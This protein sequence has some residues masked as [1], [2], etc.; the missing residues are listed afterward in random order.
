MKNSTTLTILSPSHLITNQIQGVPECQGL[1]EAP[2]FCGFGHDP[3]TLETR[4]ITAKSTAIGR[5]GRFKVLQTFSLPRRA[6]IDTAVS[7]FANS[8][9]AGIL[10]DGHGRLNFP[11]QGGAR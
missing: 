2:N 3:V 7:R 10:P 11:T 9:F 6:P 1:R 8:E 4:N 5:R